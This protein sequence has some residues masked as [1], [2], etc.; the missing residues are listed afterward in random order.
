MDPQQRQQHTLATSA[1]TILPNP[2]HFISSLFTAF[3]VSVLPLLAIL[4]YLGRANSKPNTG[5]RELR[6]CPYRIFLASLILFIKYLDDF[7]PKSQ[8]WIGCSRIDTES[9]VILYTLK[10]VNV[11]KKQLQ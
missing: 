9:T 6:P 3:S 2:E 7:P 4:I 1:E 8:L 11:M 10:E 5:A